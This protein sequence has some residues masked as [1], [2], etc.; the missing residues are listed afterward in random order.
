MILWVAHTFFTRPSINGYKPA[1]FADMV[2]GKA[3]KPFV[4]RILL[5]ATVRGIVAPIPESTRTSVNS[6]FK[7]DLNNGRWEKE[8]VLEY[9]IASLFITACLIGFYVSLRYLCTSLYAVRSLEVD[10]L[11]L[12][13]VAVLP[14]FFGY[15]GYLYDFPTLFLF[16]LSLGLMVNQKWTAYSIVFII[17][18]LNKETTILLTM[19]FVINQSKGVFALSRRR[20]LQLLAIQLAAFGIIKAVLFLIFQD[21]PGSFVE[22]HLID[23]NMQLAGRIGLAAFIVLPAVVVFVISGWGHKPLFLRNALWILVPL[24]ALTGFLGYV[25]ELRDYYEV[26]PVILL[27]CFPTVGRAFKVSIEPSS[28]AKS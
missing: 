14:S 7:Y 15:Y 18:C 9:A 6:L 1:M 28:T 21:N 11:S 26:Y 10:L 16:T 24:V 17:G 23:H 5:P 27:L 4:Y 12:A 20:F 3:Y 19:V 13:G 8:Y 25:D 2:Y 22:F